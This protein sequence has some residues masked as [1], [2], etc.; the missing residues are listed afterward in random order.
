MI[1]LLIF[2][3]YHLSI[4]PYDYF[5][6]MDKSYVPNYYFLNYY[7]QS[8]PEMPINP[9]TESMWPEIYKLQS[10]VYVDIEPEPLEVLR[11]KWQH[12][13]HCCFVYQNEEQKVMAYLLAHVWANKTPPKLYQTLSDKKEGSQLFLHDLAVSAL[14]KGSGVGKQMV[15]QLKLIAKQYN[16]SQI[17]LVAIQ[18]SVPFWQKMGFEIDH[19]QAANAS[20]GPDAKIM[21]QVL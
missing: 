15:E 18:G 12:S 4:E 1:Y 7:I 8:L 17:Q 20:Y 9:I 6:M 5:C 11:D 13:A 3:H 19:E 2:I 10:Q 21:K 14:L 16:Y